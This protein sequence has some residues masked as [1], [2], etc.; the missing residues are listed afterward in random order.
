MYYQKIVNF[1]NLALRLYNSCSFST[2]C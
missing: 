2:F 1:K